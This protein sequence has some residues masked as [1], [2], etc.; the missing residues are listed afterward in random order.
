MEENFNRVMKHYK[1]NTLI[2]V[3]SNI[4]LKSNQRID[5]FA[6]PLQNIYSKQIELYLAVITMNGKLFYSLHRKSIQL[7]I[8]IL[9]LILFM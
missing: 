7:C 6:I 4:K 3:I 8:I 9:N 2:K 1:K 5:H